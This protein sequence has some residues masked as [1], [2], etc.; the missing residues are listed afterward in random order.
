MV[1]LFFINR[2]TFLIKAPI[3]LGGD[4][5]Y[6]MNVMLQNILKGHFSV[7]FDY[8]QPHHYFGSLVQ[9]F[10]TL[11]FHLFMPTN[12]AGIFLSIIFIQ[13]ITL[14]FVLNMVTK[15]YNQSTSRWLF[16]SFILAPIGI[17]IT[18]IASDTA[19]NATLSLIFFLLLDRII[20]ND[21]Y[22]KATFISLIA[23]LIDVSFLPLA[24]YI[25]ISHIQKIKITLFK[26]KFS[27]LHFVV[28]LFIFFEFF[29]LLKLIQKT[30]TL[31]DRISHYN[32]DWAL[33]TSYQHFLAEHSLLLLKVKPINVAAFGLFLLMLFLVFLSII[34]KRPLAK[35]SKEIAAISIYFFVY[36][37]IFYY[38][39][40]DE[41]YATRT[42]AINSEYW[43]LWFYATLF[44]IVINLNF[45]KNIK[46]SF[47][48]Y[49]LLTAF[50]LMF[51]LYYSGSL[52]NFQAYNL[53][54]DRPNPRPK[55]DTIDNCIT[56]I[57]NYNFTSEQKEIAIRGCNAR[58]QDPT[59]IKSLV[60]IDG[61]FYFGIGV[62]NF[63]RNDLGKNLCLLLNDEHSTSECIRGYEHSVALKTIY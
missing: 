48:S 18:S 28:S 4:E 52:N 17:I 30:L 40:T 22:K 41:P 15:H 46:M 2:L 25:L 19:G 29:I 8:V 20:S 60:P 63:Y 3:T 43:Q 62:Q 35:K 56:A 49:L 58:E 32:L 55:M 53:D 54:F 6:E 24:L 16:I 37:L 21:D 36:A 44:L 23:I 13:T 45:I 1:I 42:L 33:Q 47:A 61:L 51:T 59:R 11:P 34:I 50:T 27:L 57:D 7:V 26:E 38:L 39:K 10:I 12:E 5:S 31:G 9:A 14:W